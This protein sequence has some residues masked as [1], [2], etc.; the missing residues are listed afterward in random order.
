[1]ADLKEKST[2]A[3]KETTAKTVKPAPA[4]EAAVAAKKAE[5]P[6]AAKKTPEKESAKKAAP[7]KK[8]AKKETAKK[9]GRKPAVKTAAKT[10]KKAAKKAPV[11]RV[12]EVY[13]EYAGQQILSSEIISK[14]EEAF[15]AEGHRISTIKD[16]R[17]YV[18][19]EEQ[20]AYYVINDKAEGKFVEL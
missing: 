9:P 8:A 5:T 1:M 13:F 3:K 19:P 17:V 4:A 11:E 18:N 12:Q 7:E 15:K 6:E 16:L 20:R 14:I 2:A 10:P